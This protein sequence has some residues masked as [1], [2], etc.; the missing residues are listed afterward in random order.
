MDSI[1]LQDLNT[2]VRQV[3]AL[4]FSE[5]IWINCEIAQIGES[6][7][8]RYL[9]LIEK[10]ED[11]TILAKASAIIWNRDY[12]NIKNKLGNLTK[13]ILSTGT[14]I[15]IKV[16]VTSHEVYGI[17]LSIM[18]IDASYTMG[19]HEIEKNK[20]IDRLKSEKLLQKNGLLKL[21]TVIQKIAVLSSKTAAGYEDFI[22]QLKE[23]EYGYKYNLNLFNVAVQGVNVEKEI[24]AALKE[25]YHG[26]EQYDTIVI[27][28]GGGSKM[29]L[30]C[31]DNYKIAAAIAYSKY[32]VISG[33]GHEI[34]DV[35]VD[36]VAHKALKT[37]TAVANFILDRSLFFE[38]QILLSY[39]NIDKMISNTLV[40]KQLYI[41]NLSHRLDSSIKIWLGNQNNKLD[42]AAKIIEMS[43]PE[44]ILAKGFFTI[45]HKNK[46]LTDITDLESGDNI[47]I[48]SHKQSR[49]A[50]IK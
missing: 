32:P 16:L 34:D 2:H 20:I 19:V 22:S 12:L 8:N 13:S 43:K 7:G 15:L 30:A 48:E 45:K 39:Q 41:E 4:N 29:D 9:E 27:I 25:I 44:K 23:N 49:K 3:I 11:S 5:A 47:E 14:K 26:E 42:M 21:P 17:K 10:S 31:F 24:I 18:D 50:T 6:R 37:P 28:R 46:I 35:I 38:S 40:Q 33:I 36:L 1:S